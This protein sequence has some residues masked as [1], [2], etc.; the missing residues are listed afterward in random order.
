M[1]PVA[2]DPPSGGSRGPGAGASPDVPR[3]RRALFRIVW[4]VACLAIGAG[5]YLALEH[6]G[7]RTST[8]GAEAKPIAVEVVAA[9]QTTLDSVLPFVGSL[10][11]VRRIWVSPVVSG[12][13]AE[14]TFQDGQ[15]V[16]AGDVLFRLDDRVAQAELSSAKAQLELDASRLDRDVKLQRSGLIPTE[17]LET[18]RAQAGQSQND[19]DIKTL[20]LQLLTIKAPFVGVLGRG[21]VDAG[22]YVNPGDQLVQLTDLTRFTAD[23]QVPERYVGRI[24]AGAAVTFSSPAVPDQSFQGSVTFID[25]AIDSGTRSV[26]VRATIENAGDRLRPG[27]F[28]RVVLQAGPPRQALAVPEAALVYQLT[29]TYVFLAQDNVARRR[30]VTA[31]IR[32]AGLVEIVQGLAAGDL[33]VTVGQS[34]LRDGMPVS[35][36]TPPP[37]G[38]KPATVAETGQAPS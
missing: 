24:A 21:L 9:R 3:G 38:A 22:Q 15:S 7:R 27:M 34:Q 11:S 16:Q 33:V 8:A 35:V 4:I 6:V 13:I 37:P 23:F 31:G 10:A 2:D 26:L 5:G 25:A 20:N 12:H 19:V 30:T 32:Q 18:S 28:G 29:G 1:P 14:I 36:S 17:S